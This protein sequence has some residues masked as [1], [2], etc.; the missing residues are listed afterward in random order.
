MKRMIVVSRSRLIRLAVLFLCLVLV[1][2]FLN[3]TLIGKWMY[4]IQ[5]RDTIEAAGQEFQVD[6]LLIAA[7]IRVESKFKEQNVSNAGAIGLMQLMPDTAQ[8]IAGQSGIPYNNPADLA[9]VNLN[10]RL[11]SWYLAYLEKRFGGSR[12][13][14]VAAYNAGPNRVDNWISTKQWDGSFEKS[15][16]IPVGETRHF[17][18]RV[19]F[20]LNMYHKYYVN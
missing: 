6:P 16:N 2:V 13:A 12:A 3:S 17:V 4:P 18:Q 8:W 14:A 5:H 7:V 19:F 20:N 15:D 1:I 11:G 9:E 10:I